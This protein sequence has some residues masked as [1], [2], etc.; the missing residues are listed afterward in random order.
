[1]T[2]DLKVRQKARDRLRAQGITIAQFAREHGYPVV[3]VY[4]VLDGKYRGDYGRAHEIAIALG[5]K[6]SHQQAA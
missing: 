5:I 4:R 3:S 1:M 2:P 6:P